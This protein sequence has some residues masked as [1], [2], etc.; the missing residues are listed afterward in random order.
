MEINNL[1]QYFFDIIKR[2][3][4]EEDIY[5]AKDMLELAKTSPYQSKDYFIIACVAHDLERSLPCRLKP[6]NFKNYD[7]FK[8]K[9]EK[10]SSEIVLRIL[11][12]LGIE[13]NFAIK[14]SKLIEKHEFGDPNDEEAQ[15][16]K[17]LDVLSFLKTNASF[18]GKR[19][20]SKEL[21]ER[22]RWGLKRLDEKQ[23]NR[24]L[25]TLEIKDKK[26]KDA[27]NKVLRT[28]I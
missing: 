27:L 28:G 19:H 1:I 14:V 7:E 24:L 3:E 2:S 10:R 25:S 9:H 6:E 12:R 5:H 15:E 20:T 22:I 18:Y 11:K 4:I 17:F 26:V 13:S 16:L 21:E 23:L 8:K